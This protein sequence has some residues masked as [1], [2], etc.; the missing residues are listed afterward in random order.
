MTS[1]LPAST[2]VLLRARQASQFELETFLLR[3][4][5]GGAFS[6]AH[7][8]PGG[9]VDKDDG[10][11]RWQSHTQ[12]LAALVQRIE[13]YLPSEQALAHAV[14]AVREVFEETGILLG[15]APPPVDSLAA[16]RGREALLSHATTFLEWC[17]AHGVYLRL[18]TLRPW[19][20]WITPET[21]RR[22]F[23]T[24]FFLAPLPAGQLATVL[25]GEAMEGHWMTPAGALGAQR[26]GTIAL[27]P[28]TLRTLEELREWNDPAQV[29]DASQQ[30][31][32]TAV[33]PR[34]LPGTTRP[35]L[36]LPGDPEYHE[37][38]DCA[39]QGPTRF[40]LHGARW[41]STTPGE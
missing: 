16:T 19:A 41:V 33:M 36:A 21:E 9:R 3:R 29:F 23:D 25:P 1:A 12:G 22:R 5:E 17:T 13:Q 30:R 11:S 39:V 14:A 34:L 27:A 4:P 37:P 26:A 32:L 40:V 6:G 8:F 31:S 24:W 18:E 38:T 35:T 28:P 20:H 7:V 10:D 15:S 2:V